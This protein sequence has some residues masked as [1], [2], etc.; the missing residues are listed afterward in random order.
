MATDVAGELPFHAAALAL[1]AKRRQLAL[2]PP[3]LFPHLWAHRVNEPR[4][5]H[6]QHHWKE[7]LA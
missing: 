4:D 5:V 7:Q 1:D 2:R 3:V 6:P